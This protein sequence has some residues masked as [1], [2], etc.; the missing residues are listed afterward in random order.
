MIKKRLR[1]GEPCAKCAQTE[2]MLRRR[3]LWDRVDEVVWAIEGEADS[4]GAVVGRRHGVDVAPFFVVRDEG[5][6]ETVFRSA[7]QLIR[8]HLSQ[9]PVAVSRTVGLPDGPDES[10]GE[11]ADEGAGE[12]WVAL[13]AE[14]SQRDPAGILRWGLER[15]GERCTLRFEGAEDVVLID[16]AMQLGLAF[17]VF[18]IDTGRLRP[19]SYRF[20][21]AVRNH[22]GVAIDLYFPDAS[23]ISELVR[24]KGPNSFLQDGHAECCALRRVAPQKRALR[25]FE[26]WVSGRRKDQRPHASPDLPVV[27]QDPEFVG[28]K[29]PIVRLNPLANWTR[30]RVWAYIEEKQVPVNELHALGFVAIGCEPCTRP[31]APDR[32]E[33]EGLW[34][35]EGAGEGAD[36]VPAGDGI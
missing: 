21:D 34:W 6:G 30:D 17:K 14:L 24:Q 12:D 15:Y 18:A 32:P 5:G 22:Y 9:A 23:A 33:R 11:G 1:N 26:A 28:A 19:E 25:K 2:E 31:T 4:P 7:L 36:A 16:M 35:W 8:T 13:A 10:P 27:L 20:L 29:G 3:G